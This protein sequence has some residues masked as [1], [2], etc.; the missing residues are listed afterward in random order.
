MFRTVWGSTRREKE[1]IAFV[2]SCLGM[3]V[4]SLISSMRQVIR[5]SD[6]IVRS[7]A[8]AVHH[9]THARIHTP[10][11]H[12]QLIPNASSQRHYPSSF[13]DSP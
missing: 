8:K 4:S 2:T 9:F 11:K 5:V 1:F 7:A 12:T 13:P 10:Y 6:A 3:H